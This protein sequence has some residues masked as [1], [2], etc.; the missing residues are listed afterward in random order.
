M[1][2]IIKLIKEY[3][4][5]IIGYAKAIW[6]KT[7][8]NLRHLF[9]GILLTSGVALGI[10]LQTAGSPYGAY[11]I[12]PS[13]GASILVWCINIIWGVAILLMITSIIMVIA[14]L[15]N[16]SKIEP[17]RQNDY[18]YRKDLTPPENKIRAVGRKL[19]HL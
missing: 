7:R 15:F 16:V 13:L 9:I 2:N 14:S 11:V 3:K 17:K 8:K 10:I 1:K 18:H 4:D 19:F 12:I 6:S 5:R